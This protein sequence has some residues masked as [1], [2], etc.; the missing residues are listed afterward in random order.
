MR[1]ADLA[2]YRAK[3]A[4]KGRVEL[5]APQMQADVVRAPS[6]RTRLRSALHD[7]E[8]ALLHQPVVELASGRITAVAAQ[9]RWRSAQGILFTP[10]EFLRARPRTR[11][12]SAAEVGRWLLEEAVSRP[13]SAPRRR[14]TG[15]RRASGSPPARCWTAPAARR[16]RRGACCTRAR[17][18]AR[19]PDP[20]V[21]GQ[22]P[23]VPLD[24]LERRLTRAA[25]ARVRIAWTAS[26]AATRRSPR[27]AGSVD[28]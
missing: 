9:A 17:A 5:Y 23:A 16:R 20:G 22:R 26:A 14:A 1:N 27:C 10:A 13:P 11:D 28:M 4:G 12:R 3:Q 6:W 7:G 21:A 8:F 18:A 2:M 24:E 25:P 19:A 15:P